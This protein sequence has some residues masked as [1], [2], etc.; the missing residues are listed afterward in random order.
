MENTRV[1]TLDRFVAT[2]LV[3][4][5]LTVIAVPA[6]AQEGTTPLGLAPGSPAGTYALSDLDQINLFGGGL[7][8]RLPLVAVAGRGEAAAQSFLVVETHWGLA[9]NQFQ[10]YT[11][12]FNWWRGIEPGYGPGALRI[13]RDTDGPPNN[14]RYTT[15]MTFT[16]SDQ[17][18]YEFRDRL[19]EGGIRFLN[20]NRGK[21]FKTFD[22]SG[23]TFVSD[24][25]IIEPSSGD[26]SG[27]LMFPNGLEYRIDNGVVTRIRDRNGNV[28]RATYG[29]A[30]FRV[31]PQVATTTDGL[32]RQVPSPTPRRPRRWM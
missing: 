16:T 15:R 14:R 1:V 17:T 23:L 7:S 19:T 8:L 32:N 20:F 9:V 18:Q 11:P 25:D 21:E 4:C 29:T 27:R 12:R 24:N 2:A 31:G 30:F 22:G 13:Y 26:P 3:A 5:C 28:V 10:Q 6:L